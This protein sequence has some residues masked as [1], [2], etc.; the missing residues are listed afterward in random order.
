MPK[1]VI[2]ALAIF[3]APVVLR[4]QSLSLAAVIPTQSLLARDTSF[5]RTAPVL[6]VPERENPIRVCN[7]PVAT[8][9]TPSPRAARE[10][11]ISVPRNAAVQIPTARSGCRSGTG[12]AGALPDTSQLRPF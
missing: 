11:G 3:F 10:G 7:M 9:G 5:I 12:D 2:L 1:R 6:A 4:A 8:A